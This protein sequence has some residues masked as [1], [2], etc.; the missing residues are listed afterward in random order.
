MAGNSIS[1][2]N[3]LKSRA[4]MAF[5]GFVAANLV[6]ANFA[7]PSSRKLDESVI[8][9]SDCET[10][11]QGQWT[12]WVARNYLMQKTPPDIAVF[13]SSQMGS[14]NFAAD[15][16]MLNKDLDLTQ[17]RRAS[18]LATMLEKQTGVRPD[19]YQFAMGGAMA[20]DT[21]MISRALF[22]ENCKPKMVVVGVNPRDFIDNTLPSVSSTEPFQFFAPYVEIGSLADDAFPDFFSHM[23]WV[24]DQK[25]PLK[26]LHHQVETE[27][28]A[29][30]KGGKTDTMAA[31][32]PRKVHKELLRAVLG[33]A[34]EV[35]PGEWILP[36]TVPA[37]T[38][39]DNTN[40]YLRRY[41]SANSPI[42]KGE[43]AFFNAFLNDMQAK[44]IKVLVVG[45]PS[46]WP[47]R[48][49]LPDSFWQ[50]FRRDLTTA[51]SSHGAEFLDLTDSSQFV[52]SDFLDT[53]HLNGAGG[54]KLFALVSRRIANTPSLAASFSSPYRMAG[55]EHD[56]AD[57]E[58]HNAS[59]GSWH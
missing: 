30:A 23:A 8:Q 14:A 27:L 38:F 54:I 46:L 40:E 35:R 34:D 22:T 13:G 11:Q 4:I 2:S 53:V 20:S 37:S 16:R 15:A 17:Y 47:N 45:M 51:T 31:A 33:A 6:V 59:A 29:L 56:F 3:V 25:V 32:K 18:T 50:K 24:V 19:T 52:L 21:L 28:V 49:L 58:R 26:R 9:K 57:G 1:L 10:R 36:A 41:K 7:L 48:A 42:Y 39:E 43:M 12:W 55:R 5:M 44:D